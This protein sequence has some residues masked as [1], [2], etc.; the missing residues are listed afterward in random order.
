[1]DVDTP[2]SQLPKMFL[3]LRGGGILK[4][5]NTHLQTN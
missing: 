4:A 3:A 5:K 2:L 1:M